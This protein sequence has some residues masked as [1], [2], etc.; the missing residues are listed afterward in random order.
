[1]SRLTYPFCTK[2]RAGSRTLKA[3]RLDQVRRNCEPGREV[4]RAETVP[5]PPRRFGF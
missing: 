1:M 3:I 5:E 4:L 2:S